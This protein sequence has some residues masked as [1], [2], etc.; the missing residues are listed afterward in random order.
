MREMLVYRSTENSNEVCFTDF[1]IKPLGYDDLRRTKSGCQMDFPI[2]ATGAT[3]ASSTIGL[4]T[5]LKY[6]FSVTA[7][8]SLKIDLYALVAG[9]WLPPGMIT[10]SRVEYLLDRCAVSLLLGTSDE[11]RKGHFIDFLNSQNAV[12]NPFMH[13][14]ESP[15]SSDGV[16]PLPTRVLLDTTE[17]L[18]TVLPDAEHMSYKIIDYLELESQLQTLRAYRELISEFL[19]DFHPVIMSPVSRKNVPRV[20][21]AI[22]RSASTMGIPTL[23]IPILAAISAVLVPN[24]Q[25]PARQIIKPAEIRK[26]GNADN[27]AN[28]L[29][30]LAHLISRHDEKDMNQVSFCT[31]DRNL[32][33]FW[34]GLRPH[35]VK[36]GKFAVNIS[37]DLFPNHAELM[38][39]LTAA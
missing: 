13:A 27:A 3:V 2:A 5:D 38:P 34:A 28:D 21:R 6:D 11:T 4:D 26:K 16:N 30:A 18:R 1:K 9:G 23:S 31:W 36:P 20:L 32:A 24:G 8:N 15:T 19:E 14:F 29:V 22:S 17:K 25:S 37:D 10:G 7:R 35:L 39:S 12:L 33:L